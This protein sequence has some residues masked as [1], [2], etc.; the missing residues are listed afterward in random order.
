MNII[1]KSREVSKVELYRMTKSPEVTSLSKIADNTEIK[2]SAFLVYEDVKTTGEIA[3]LLAILSDE[4][5]AYACE[6]QTFRTSF[7]E[8]AEIFD[9]EDFAIRKISGTTKA[10]RPYINCVLA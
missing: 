6:S 10:G 4:G 7:E 5:V 2:V 9:G 1:R 8:I 3:T